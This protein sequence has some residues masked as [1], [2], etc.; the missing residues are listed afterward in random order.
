MYNYGYYSIQVLQY[1][2]GMMLW[3]Q[4]HPLLPVPEH[5]QDTQ[6]I[7]RLTVPGT[8]HHF[9]AVTMAIQVTAES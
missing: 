9:T 2:V 5:Y 1:P 8:V 4:T 3:R 6:S 7:K